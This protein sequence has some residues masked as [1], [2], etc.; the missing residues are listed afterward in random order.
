MQN[1]ELIRDQGMIESINSYSNNITC[2]NDRSETTILKDVGE[3]TE[4]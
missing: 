3:H 1:F 2:E 4:K